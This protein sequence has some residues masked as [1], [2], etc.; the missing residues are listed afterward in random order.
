M[1]AAAQA[2]R[3]TCRNLVNAAEPF[4]DRRSR[5]VVMERPSCRRSLTN[6]VNYEQPLNARQFP[7]NRVVAGCWHGNDL[8]LP[9]K[10][11]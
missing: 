1:A 9:P 8:R 2:C 3:R 4:F 5:R 7:A 11:V 6:G 10:A